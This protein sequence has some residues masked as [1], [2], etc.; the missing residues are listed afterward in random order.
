MHK[1]HHGEQKGQNAEQLPGIAVKQQILFKCSL[2][3]P[4]LSET[5]GLQPHWQHMKNG[6]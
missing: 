2:A 5:K 1:P 6:V 4:L 3:V